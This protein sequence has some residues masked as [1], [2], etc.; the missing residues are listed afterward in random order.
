M[1]VAP[2]QVGRWR[3]GIRGRCG[4]LFFLSFRKPRLRFLAGLRFRVIL[5]AV[6]A[7]SDQG[8]LALVK[9]L[10]EGVEQYVVRVFELKASDE[11]VGC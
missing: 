2:G 5:I 9:V 1:L 4:R 10:S 6:L 8:S 3:R 11:I 7:V